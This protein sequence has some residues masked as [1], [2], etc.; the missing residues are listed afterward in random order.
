MRFEDEHR[1]M[2]WDDDVF[3]QH[4]AQSGEICCR[5]SVKTLAYLIAGF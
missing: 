4:E 1:R 3:I 5:E 2:E